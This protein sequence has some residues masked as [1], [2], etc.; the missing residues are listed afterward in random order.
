M[1]CKMGSKMN[2]FILELF[3]E[4]IPAKMQV[5][6]AAQLLDAFQEGLKAQTIHY[7]Q[8]NFYVTPRRITIIAEGLPDFLPEKQIEKKGPKL[9]ARVEAIDGFLRSV[10]MKIEDLVQLDGFYYAKK[11]EPAKN[12][13]EI[14]KL[15]LENLLQ[16]FTWP[17]SMRSP[18]GSEKWVRPLR[19][20]MCLFNNDVLEI[21][22]GSLKANNKSF[23]HRFMG[24]NELL[25]I[26]SITD[27]YEKLKKTFVVLSHEERK[28]IIIA[29]I[30]K[31]SKSLGLKA[32]IDEN[33]LNE[34]V[35]L[36]E[37]PHVIIGKIEPVFMNLP[38]EVLFTAMK[39]HQRYFYLEDP[40]DGLAPYFI[41]VANVDFGNDEIIIAGNE[42]VLKARLS[43]AKFFFEQDLKQPT[44]EALAKLAKMTFHHK[45]GTMF[46]KVNRIIH[47]AEYLARDKLDLQIVKKAA[48]LCKTDLV[49]EMVGEFPEL[50]GV[51]GKYYALNNSQEPEVCEAIAEHYRPIDAS[52]QGNVSY[53]GAIIAIADKIDS[54]V[55][56]WLAG[57]KP[58]S[59][60]DPFALRRAAL[61]IIKLI[62]FHKLDLSIS[63]LINQ[64]LQN[65]NIN[66]SAEQ[67]KEI[68]IFFKDRIKFYFK[69]EHYRHDVITA[70]LSNE[71]DN[72]NEA[73]SNV[74]KLEQFVKTQESANLLLAIKRVLSILSQSKDKPDLQIEVNLLNDI[75]KELYNKTLSAESSINGLLTLID[76][77][78]R[79]F[80][81]VMVNDSNAKL[82][83]NRLNLLH[84]IASLSKKIADFAIIEL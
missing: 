42:K 33:L 56:L 64:A 71:L 47:L 35:G 61:G 40:Q 66:C 80:D 23:G 76:P 50:Q 3:S 62:Y 13:K 65:Y 77:I 16:N 82:R 48:L 53:L 59:S 52:D 57:E 44:S 15:M 74:D 20:I 18:Q 9:D 45:L 27:Y 69:G 31:A 5:K 70:V 36:V 10:A 11:L 30:H 1:L 43:D 38:K 26:S 46:D 79:F 75:E 25:S 54:I 21:N 63:E 8:A 78:N 51:M 81:H 4:E 14:L 24:G 41:T 28:N 12:V 37:Y 32:V 55:G 49:S 22:F 17:K 67:Q 68:I 39:V 73:C 58:S 84:N 72:I 60:K 19:N 2:D 34:V 83:L 7:R 6:A 29:Q